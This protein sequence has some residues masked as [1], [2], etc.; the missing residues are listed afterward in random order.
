VFSLLRPARRS[1][2]CLRSLIPAGLSGSSKS[3][4]TLWHEDR[5]SPSPLPRC[6]LCAFVHQYT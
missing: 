2:G 3:S 1:S 6:F 5:Y 4:S